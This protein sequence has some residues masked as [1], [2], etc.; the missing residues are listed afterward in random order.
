MKRGRQPPTLHRRG[1]QCVRRTA[2]L[3]WLREW[4]EEWRQ[5]VNEVSAF[6]RV[7]RGLWSRL[8]AMRVLEA[9]VTLDE[10]MREE[11]EP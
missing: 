7:Q 9:E 2:K 5:A 1:E 3:I 11:I 10:Y 8:S 6:I 4:N